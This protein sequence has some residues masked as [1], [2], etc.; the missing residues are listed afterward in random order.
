MYNK[1]TSKEN[2]RNISI[3]TKRIIKKYIKHKKL[4]MKQEKERK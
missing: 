4:K 1:R 2:K 3:K